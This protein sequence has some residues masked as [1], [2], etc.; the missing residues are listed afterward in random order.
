MDENTVEQLEVRLGTGGPDKRTIEEIKDKLRL[1]WMRINKKTEGNNDE[2][3]DNTAEETALAAQGFKGRCRVCGKWGHKA[4]VCRDKDKV[5]NN[6]NGNSNNNNR[7][8][9][10]KKQ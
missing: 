7:N 6:K 10:P 2:L 4:A 3:E 1:K 9:N 8:G 5:Q